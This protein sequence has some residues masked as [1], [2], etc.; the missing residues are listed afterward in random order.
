MMAP[1]AAIRPKPMQWELPAME[2][3]DEKYLEDPSTK[4]PRLIYRHHFL[5][6]EDL[7]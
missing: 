1:R 7:T 4:A 2:F 6:S 5:S 3:E